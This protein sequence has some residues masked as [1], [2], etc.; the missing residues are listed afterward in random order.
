MRLS[1]LLVLTL[2]CAGSNAALAQSTPPTVEIDQLIKQRAYQQAYELAT[3]QLNEWE[4]NVD[5]DFVYGVA[6][7]ESGNPNEAVFAFERVARTAPNP[8]LR[9]RARLELARAHFI[10]NNLAASEDLFNRVL[11][12]NPPVNVQNNIRTF[13]AL[14]EARRE[15]QRS[16]ISFTISPFIGHD[17]NINSATADG[18]IDT[19]GI[20]EVTLSEEG[21]KTEDDFT[22]ITIGMFYKRPI[23][24]DKSID[25][26][27][28]LNRHDNLSTDTF[29][30]S[31]ALGDVS[32]SYGNE[33]NR[34]RHSL[35]AQKAYLD[36][37]AFQMTYR[38]NN[39]WQRAV[40]NGWY[41]SLSGTIGTTRF[42]NYGSATKNHLKDTNQ[43]LVS[44][45]LTKL[46]RDF[47]NGLTFF[48]GKDRAQN[49]EGKHNGKEFV[50]LGYSV[51]WRL[52]P[53][54]TPFA[55]VS[56]QRT[57][58]GDRHPTFINDTREDKTLSATLGWVWQHSPKLSAN[59]DATFTENDSNIPLFEYSRF[60]Y[61]AG[62][63]YQF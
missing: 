43:V 10:T 59:I 45:G 41:Q 44:A 1:P 50:G 22:D 58:H 57:E 42:D 8:V 21:L 7:I 47:T 13:L 6:A 2:L 4:G 29:D 25:V 16:S 61:Q 23:S 52:T 34:F 32:Y 31:Y 48:V 18:L 36:G 3:S 12:S 46:S 33:N 53:E 39:S 17:N 5:F 62:I 54:H 60:R 26:S 14:I 63:R 15:D 28:N 40:S 20:G 56:A 19:P 37:N 24:R 11:A 51:Y 30:L 49:S 27:L 35:Q 38:L 55:R 9:E